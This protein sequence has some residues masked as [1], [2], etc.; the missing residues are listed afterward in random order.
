MRVR[1]QLCL[2]ALA[3]I[4]ILGAGRE[5]GR[6]A[7]ARAMLAVQQELRA[8][9][10]AAMSDGELDQRERHRLERDSSERLSPQAFSAFRGVLDRMQNSSAPTARPPRSAP[11]SRPQWARERDAVKP[12][13]MSQVVPAIEGP[14]IPNLHA[15]TEPA[16]EPDD[17]EIATLVQA[18][19]GEPYGEVPAAAYP[20]EWFETADGLLVH[21]ASAPAG[22]TMDDNPFVEEPG[23]VTCG[24]AAGCTDTFAGCTDTFVPPGAA[25]YDWIQ[26]SSTVDAFQGPMDLDGL[27]A[28]YGMRFA[29]NAALPLSRRFGLGVQ[30]GT[31]GVIADVHGTPFTGSRER[32]QNFTTVGLF[33]RLCIG[34]GALKYG[35][36]YDWL[37]DDYYTDFA[38]SQWRVKLAWE[39]SPVTEIGLWST[40]PSDGDDALLGAGT[41]NPTLDAFKPF[42]QGS[43]YW[44]RCWENGSTTTAYIGVA[45]EPG[46]WVFGSDARIPM[47]PRLA[48]IGNVHY[49]APSA[50]GV[51]AQEEEVW[52]VS[53]G[54]EWT[55]GAWAN[56]CRV[57]TFRPLFR[58]AD[59]GLFAVRRY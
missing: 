56:R 53:V 17:P 6:A 40:I 47:T 49:I 30:A 46:A 13:A 9:L 37:F 35:F 11:A 21:G 3:A 51:P 58:L 28:N 18:T 29:V 14:E 38:M 26:F 22:Q 42:A 55:P 50:E 2:A 8:E 57:G 16:M 33:Q 4:G 23:Q 12:V 39:V 59:N 10:L 31:S 32:R 43:L 34:S 27:N 25:C 20:V 19:F 48:F 24:T 5:A 44:K 41:D 54:L 36:A 45:D 7:D 52:N 15:T 1:W